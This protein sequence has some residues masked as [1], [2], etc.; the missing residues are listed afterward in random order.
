MAAF[1]N[2]SSQTNPPILL[3]DALK[4]LAS[5]GSAAYH[6]NVITDE[7]TWSMNAPQVLGTEPDTTVT[8]KRF[9]NF[10]NPENMSS[11]Y[12][13][14]VLAKTQDTGQGV[15]FELEYSFCAKGKD[16]PETWLEDTGRWFAGR[17]GKPAEVFGLVRRI[18]KRHERDQ[19]LS[20]TSHRDAL[21]GFMNHNRLSETL[22]EAISSCQL[23][24]TQSA[25]AIIVINNLPHVN[26][27]YGFEIA[28]EVI[29]A[30]GERLQS[31]MRGGD[32]IARYSGSKFGIILNACTPTDLPLALER[33]L[34]VVR[35][36]VIE[37]TRGPVWAM[38]AI[39][40]IT[41]PTHA[42]DAATA[43]AH[44]EEALND[45]RR[46]VTDKAVIYSISERRRNEQALNARCAAEIVQTLKSD[47][48]KLAFQPIN[49]ARTGETVMHEALLRMIDES[50][51][52]I[53]A[54]HLIPVA[55]SLGLVRLID[56]TVTQMTMATLNAYPDARISM[57]I[58]ATTATDPRWYN[59]IIEIIESN[60]DAASRLTVEITETVAMQNIAATSEFM[61]RLRK[62]GCNIAIDD[63]GAG[64]TSFRNMRDLPLTL[65]KLDGSFCRSLKDNSDNA[66]FV[67]SMVQ[68]A[69]N[70]DL[71]II[72]EWVES[73]ADAE[74]LAS[75]GVNFVQGNGI[76]P[77]TTRLPW[78]ND[79]SASLQIA[80]N[81]P[82]TSATTSSAAER[83]QTEIIEE[84]PAAA[85][86]VNVDELGDPA[87]PSKNAT[88]LS[89]T[90]DEEVDADIAKLRDTLVLLDRFFPT[91]KQSDTETETENVAA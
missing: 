67:K 46:H 26:Q 12:D 17:D 90:L 84:I 49:D 85:V 1:E 13:T 27:A 23:E 52:I 24:G 25:L 62:N 54:G 73:P 70:F 37:T 5:S 77:A 33:L 7:L 18:D 80:T 42:N 31:I 34:A 35:D 51:E 83:I 47:N 72:A 71:K 32:C 3:D 16:E 11:R 29:V 10:L 19:Q 2:P 68:L 79:T 61:T 86:A 91:P 21:T 28:D 75:W 43:M 82:S 57:N 14:V 69:Q 89:P 44:A 59:Q 6:W 56:R 40:G 22:V 38:I 81:E 9:A 41:I 87:A 64:F 60:S 78:T 48:F 15:A 20:A 66:F 65:I 53:T 8:G 88:L 55:E 74:L 50:G 63:F 76:G 4:A 45:A 58:S 36:S 39:G 30:I